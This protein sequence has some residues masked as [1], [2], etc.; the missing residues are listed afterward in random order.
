MAV[1]VL[2]DTVRSYNASQKKGW[3][4]TETQKLE[5]GPCLVS[6][7]PVM[8]SH[9]SR[10]VISEPNRIKGLFIS[11]NDCWNSFGQCWANF[12]IVLHMEEMSINSEG[13]PNKTYLRLFHIP[14]E[15]NYL[16]TLI[17][18]SALFYR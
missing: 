5:I 3:L 4:A 16:L 8:M 6:G 12:G 14:S 15:C 9:V 18:R 11:Q 1:N 7:N 2:K 17:G 13:P 10:Q